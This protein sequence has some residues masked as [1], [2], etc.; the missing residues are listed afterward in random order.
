MDR[1]CRCRTKDIVMKLTK[2]LSIT[3]LLSLTSQFMAQDEVPPLTSVLIHKMKC[4]PNYPF[5]AGDIE[6][7]TCT[8]STC[9]GNCF[10][11]TFGTAY[12]SICVP[13][14][15]SETCLATY[16]DFHWSIQTAGCLS[17]SG[18]CG[19]DTTWSAGHTETIS[20]PT[21]TS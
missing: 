6:N 5:G 8:S 2:I 13:G 7:V 3:V 19:C 4:Y 11:R 17:V 18:G 9:D 21:C 1:N 15:A 16:M 12:V 20:L 14:T 10:K